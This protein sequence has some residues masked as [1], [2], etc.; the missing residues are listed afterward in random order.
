MYVAQF[1][2][3][4]KF[5]VGFITRS[6]ILL[7]GFRTGKKWPP[8]QNDRTVSSPDQELAKKWVNLIG[9]EKM[10]GNEVRIVGNDVRDMIFSCSIHNDISILN[11]E[12]ITIRPFAAL[13]LGIPLWNYEYVGRAEIVEFNRGDSSVDYR[14]RLFEVEI[15]RSHWIRYLA[16]YLIGRPYNF[17]LWYFWHRWKHE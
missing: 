6:M 8:K 1:I 5:R 11:G 16:F 15:V 12:T 10:N 9:Y 2:E 4:L 3:M 13:I 7:G 14:I 17:L